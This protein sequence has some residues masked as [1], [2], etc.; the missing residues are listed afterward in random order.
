M[1]EVFNCFVELVKTNPLI[2]NNNNNTLHF[3]Q[4]SHLA[5]RLNIFRFSKFIY[6]FEDRGTTDGIYF[7]IYSQRPFE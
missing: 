3:S 5:I 1:K 4:Y 6:S 7:G 2:S